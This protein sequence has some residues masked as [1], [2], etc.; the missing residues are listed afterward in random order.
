MPRPALFTHTS[1]EPKAASASSRKRFTSSRRVTS[2]T[3]DWHPPPASAATAR[4]ASARR[5]ARTSRQRLRPSRRAS[6]APMPLLAPVMTTTRSFDICSTPLPIGLACR[7]R[8]C[9]RP[10]DFDGV[11]VF[12]EQFLQHAHG[13]AIGVGEQAR[14]LARR[15]QLMPNLPLDRVAVLGPERIEKAS[16]LVVRADVENLDGEDARPRQRD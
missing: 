4:R 11:A 6:A 8:Q 9:R 16:A 10:N 13:A 12:P 3:T 7:W 14:L 1:T 2:A 5:A 15:V